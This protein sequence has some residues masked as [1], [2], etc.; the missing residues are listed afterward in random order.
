[1]LAMLQ[2]KFENTK[3]V[4]R[5]HLKKKLTLKNVVKTNPTS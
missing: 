3:E 4:I 2:E 1:M 5:T